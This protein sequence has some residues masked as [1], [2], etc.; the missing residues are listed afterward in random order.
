M[1]LLLYIIECLIKGLLIFLYYLVYFNLFPKNW[2]SNLANYLEDHF[3]LLCQDL[4]KSVTYKDCLNNRI[5][6]TNNLYNVKQEC[7]LLWSISGNWVILSHEDFN[8]YI[9]KDDLI[10]G[11][12]IKN[13]SNINNPEDFI[14]VDKVSSQGVYLEYKNGTLNFVDISVIK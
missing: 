5:K 8:K 10:N 6:F 13:T 3:L 9:T 7:V 11:F 2:Y 4:D 1:G 14:P 12:F